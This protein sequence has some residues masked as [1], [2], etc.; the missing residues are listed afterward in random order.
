MKKI[1]FFIFMTITFTNC[2]EVE[3]I[4][5]KLPFEQK[6]VALGFMDSVNGVR[7]YVG[8]NVPV[9]SND[10]TSAIKDVKVELWSGETMLEKLSYLD[11]N[12]FVI[13]K[14]ININPSKSYYFKAT[15]PLSMDTLFSEK[16][17]L[18]TTIPIE[19]VRFQYKNVE[20][21]TV[22]LYIEITDPLGFNAYSFNIQRYKKDTLFGKMI[23]DNP[24]FI[25]S[26]SFLYSDREYEGKKHIFI[27]ENISVEEY[28]DNR[29][30]EIDKIRVTLFNLSKPTYDAFLSF[31]TLEPNV[32]EPFFEPSI[33]SNRIK[34]GLGIF[35]T[36]SSFSFDVN[37]R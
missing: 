33:I 20:K 30:I 29:F 27:L 21:T 2:L 37:I 24:Y 3:T 14:N 23:I 17:M 36:Y 25:P 12:V 4:D 9:L 11:K 35:G 15:T 22:D 5:Y 28:Q 19:N 8:K 1:I 16:V 31:R 34:N 13:L 26:N 6:T 18:P 10:S 32:G 7:V